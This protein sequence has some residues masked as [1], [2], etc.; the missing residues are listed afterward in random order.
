MVLLFAYGSNMAPQRL[1]ARVERVEYVACGFLLGYALRF[2]KVGMDGSAK[3]DAYHTGHKQDLV[4]GAVFRLPEAEHQRLDEHEAGYDHATV[5]VHSLNGE[6][7]EAVTYVAQH[8]NID[9][10]LQPFGWYRELVLAGAFQ[11]ALPPEYIQEIERIEVTEDSDVAR[12][13][14]HLSLLEVD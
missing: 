6:S 11:H 4:W 10:T 9:P 3:A 14:H 7:F 5:T 8:D 2:H 12:R 1:R 13:D